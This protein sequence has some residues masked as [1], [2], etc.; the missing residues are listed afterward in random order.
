MRND[1]IHA[2]EKLIT[3]ALNKTSLIERSILEQIRNVPPP[4][5][6][7]HY[8]VETELVHA[9]STWTWKVTFIP[10]QNDLP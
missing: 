6:G 8:E 9:G 4:P 3:I 10:K 7:Y 1:S 2:W 5:E